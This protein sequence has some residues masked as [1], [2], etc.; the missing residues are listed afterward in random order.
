MPLDPIARIA[1]RIIARYPDH[2]ARSLARALVEKSNGAITLDAARSRVR[3]E[4]GLINNK[5]RKQP[6]FKRAP[7]EPGQGIAAPVSV[8]KPW[9]RY[10]FPA[11]GPVGIL[12][13]IHIPYHSD[14][15]LA[16]AVAKLKR[17]KVRGILI[18]GDAV[19]FYSI[20]RWE[21]NPAERDFKRELDQSRQ[22]FAWLRQEFRRIPIVLKLGNHEER[23]QSWLFQHAP[24]ISDM[25]EMGLSNWLHLA[26]HGID[27]V[28]DQRPV[29]LG[30]LTVLH[31][32][33]LPRQLA[34][35]VNAARGAW[36]R[37]KTTV[38][39][40]HHHRTSGHSEP[41]MWHEETFSWSCGCLADL[42]PAYSV[43]NS[44]NHGFAICDVGAGGSF[45]VRNYRIADDGS[46]RSS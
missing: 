10:E 29:M 24:E 6:A 16:A 2:P 5:G 38:L 20:S 18:N 43:I 9:L 4:L 35:P 34:S 30:K 17:D 25:P 33:E 22:F 11:T 1:Q 21:K 15:A 40:G 37:T 39:V 36:V 28:E 46:V 32:H 19:D 3:R 14:F 44:W 13:D 8:A 42:T 12:S 45:D 7:R 27:L 41:N 31:G 23:W 26:R